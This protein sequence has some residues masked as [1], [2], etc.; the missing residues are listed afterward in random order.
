M[1]VLLDR[2]V[3]VLIAISKLETGLHGMLLGV[4]YLHAYVGLL[5]GR[6]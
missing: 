2:N 1:S 6:S 4:W 3:K 5:G